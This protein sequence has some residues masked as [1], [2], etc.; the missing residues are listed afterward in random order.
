[1]S[2]LLPLDAAP[3]VSIG[4]KGVSLHVGKNEISAREGRRAF[5]TEWFQAQG[6]T[7]AFLELDDVLHGVKI[8]TVDHVVVFNYA[9]DQSGHSIATAANLPME[10]QANV[11]RIDQAIRQLHRAKICRVDVVTDHG[12]LYVEPSEVDALGR[13]KVVAANTL[14]KGPRYALLKADA[15]APDLVRIEAPLVPGW[16]VGLPRGIRTLVQA[17]LYEHGGVSL[18]ECVIPHLISES[19]VV[20]ETLQVQIT[21]S[22]TQLNGRNRLCNGA[23]G[24]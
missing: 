18:Q 13:P 19:A 12:F 14:N 2:A 11:A 21:P 6:R 17:E 5:L 4:V 3:R 7:V 24:R 10:V 22:T 9:L 20:P 15:P 8:P 23:A 1:M 16:Y